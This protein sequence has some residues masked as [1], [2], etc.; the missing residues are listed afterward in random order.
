MPTTVVLGAIVAVFLIRGALRC[1]LAALKLNILG[2][3]S[4]FRRCL[5]FLFSETKSLTDIHTQQVDAVCSIFYRCSIFNI[6][7]MVSCNPATQ[8]HKLDANLVNDYY[9]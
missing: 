3:A 8:A 2:M 1:F 6:L 4:G 7:Q 9:C 5:L